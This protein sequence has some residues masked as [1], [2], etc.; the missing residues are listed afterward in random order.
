MNVSPNQHRNTAISTIVPLR[1]GLG[2]EVLPVLRQPLDE[3]PSCP[4]GIEICVGFRLGGEAIASLT[5]FLER[6]RLDCVV[7]HATTRD[8]FGQLG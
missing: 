7:N 6:N 3:K 1:S 8:S 2:L 5:P 4:A